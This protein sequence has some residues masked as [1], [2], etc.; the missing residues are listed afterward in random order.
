MILRSILLFCLLSILIAGNS[1]AA[2]VS[3]LSETPDGGSGGVG[4][5]FGG[6]IELR[7]NSFTTGSNP[8]GYNLEAITLRMSDAF[9]FSGTPS[10][11]SL[12]LFSVPDSV[13]ETPLLTFNGDNNPAVA[14][15]YT[16]TTPGFFLTPNTTYAWVA[17]APDSPID[18]F[19]LIRSTSSPNESSSD[20]W[21][22]ADQSL[23][24]SSFSGTWQSSGS[25]SAHQFSV[26]ATA[27]PEPSTVGFLTMVS[28]ALVS[29]TRSRRRPLR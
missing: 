11:F 23:I 13:P 19:Y 2:L 17:S 27:I 14:G 5:N 10:G 12:E 18:T 9:D 26:S 28:V 24:L 25:L 1:R 8:L 16:Y 7:S 20:D 3:N 15:D 21:L 4:V 29:R 22:I 6:F